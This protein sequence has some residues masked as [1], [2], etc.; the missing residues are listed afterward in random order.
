MPM[1]KVL[2]VLPEMD[3]GGGQKMAVEIAA[4]VKD[5]QIQVRVLSL[6]P[7]RHTV[8]D[9]LASR[10]EVN[11]QY[12]SKKKGIDLRVIC[13]LYRAIKEFKPDVIHAHLRVMPYLL[14]PMLLNG[15]PLRYY[16]VHSLADK[17]NRHAMVRHVLAFS[18]RHCKV[19]P[20][21]ISEVC[22]K[23][24][25]QVYHL[26]QESIPCIY[27]GIDIQRFARTSPYSGGDQGMVDF[28]AVGRL[29]PEK[30]YA[31]MLAA[32]HRA[33]QKQANIRLIVL[34]DGGL[35]RELED[36]CKSLAL[37]GC[38]NLRGVTDDV[39]DHLHRAQVFLMSSDYEGL[40]VSVLEAMAAGLPIIST[41]AGGVVDVVE[42]R[43]NGLLVDV[44][45][46]DGLAA[47]IERLARDPQLRAA[48]SQRSLQLA[49]KYSIE[50][51]AEGYLKLYMA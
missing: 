12:L 19:K 11:V 24:I 40:P 35:R 48:F 46:E 43:G 13:Q 18:F 25:S 36:R 30:N 27:N 42:N 4:H 17:E 37:E 31:L 14:L 45:D 50:A 10:H 22:R 9:E 1:K 44:G 15:T 47:A 33:H 16:T 20:V 49:Q 2:T 29:S 34:G 26:P 28:I 21:A 39:E 32:F 3:V 8:I 5:E 7:C 23:S 6:Y 51:C 38:V 41:K